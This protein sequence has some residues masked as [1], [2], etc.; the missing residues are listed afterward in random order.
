MVYLF[1]VSI[2]TRLKANT[3]T[4]I[5]AGV[6]LESGNSYSDSGAKF[7]KVDQWPVLNDNEYFIDNKT[8]DIYRESRDPR[9]GELFSLSHM[10]YFVSIIRPVS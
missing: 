10:L 7:I 8:C 5:S 9:N 6:V 1:H 3:H 4:L 2:E